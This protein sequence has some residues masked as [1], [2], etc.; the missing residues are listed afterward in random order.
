MEKEL[1][2]F[3]RSLSVSLLLS[4]ILLALSAA[5]ATSQTTGTIQGRVTSAGTGN[6]IA[7]VNVVV[8]GTTKGAAA[9]FEGKYVIAEIP[10]GTYTLKFSAVGYGVV[11]K[12]DVQVG[13]GRTTTS[14]ASLSEETIHMGDVLVTAASLRPEKITDAP[15]AV[16]V[17]SAKEITLEANHGQ[18]P[19]ALEMQPGVEMVQS[20]VNDFN[21]NIRGFNSSLNRRILV[22][23]D[24]RDTAIPLLSVQEWTTVPI[25]PEDIKRVELVRGPG[26]ALYGANAY[27]GVINI[28]SA[29][30]RDVLGARLTAGGGELSTFRGDTRY[31]AA[32]G[33]WSYKLNLGRVQSDTWSKDRTTL[34]EY[35]GLSTER[36]AL[37]TGD[38]YTN[39]G[40]ARLDRDFTD[41]SV[42]TFEGGWVQTARELFVTGIGRV[43]VGKTNKPWGRANYASRNINAQVW[44]SSRNSSEPNYSL[45][46]GIPIEDKSYNVHMEFQNNFSLLENRFRIVWG[47]SQ[48]FQHT[49]TEGTLLTGV[50]DDNF[51]GF[52]GQAEYQFN[53]QW[54]GVVAGRVDRSTL[55]DTRVS[56]KAAI[57]WTPTPEHSLRTTFNRGFQVPNY[58]EFDLNV[59]AGL[60]NLQLLE[61]GIEQ[62]VAAALGLPSINL[63]L[64][65]SS[66][67]PIVAR[68][69]ENL[70]V[71]TITGFE[72]GYKGIFGR[73][74]YITVDAYYNRLED[75]VTD[76]LQAVNPSLPTYQVPN[77][78]G[79]LPPVAI[80]AVTAAIQG[81]V[82]ANA[83]GL[84]TLPTSQQVAGFPGGT[85]PAGFNA[86]FVSYSNAGRVNEYGGEFTVNY[87]ATDEVLLGAN[88]SYFRFEV[89]DKKVGDVLLPN[90]PKH[91]GN[92][93]VSYLGKKANA[94]LGLRL[95][96]SFQWAAGVFAGKIP[97][98]A[99]VNVAGNYEVYKNV[100]LGATV[101]N[102][103]DKEHYEIFGGSIIGRRAVGTVTVTF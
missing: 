59:L 85:I 54:K 69:N 39:Y 27:N 31:A 58:S 17:L 96:E 10:P 79:V 29:S 62:Q 20:G 63:P 53:D 65:F 43:Q 21:I 102:L 33:P 12:T 98:Y 8:K 87:Y 80:P 1:V 101:T 9:D 32:S 89:K 50:E 42:L 92:V 26:S 100:R 37:D 81:A 3:F 16:S 34:R 74:L 99:L 94:S 23:L 72:A 60:A 14:D 73:K 70:E 48:R 4:S 84:G 61:L 67:T 77:L 90:S 30:P 45:S 15:A 35:S 51:T 6:A 103:F 83:P 24:G 91:R 36:R 25:P 28:V 7:G 64:N 19:R 57:V 71:E 52:F 93:S 13:G 49:D 78:S 55:Y 88:Y 5:V 75:F 82:K 44:A 47:A 76:L 68:G 46:A 38:I 86:I 11:E 95:V 66:S 2:R 56:P 22:L 97:G 41:G 18:L 40:S